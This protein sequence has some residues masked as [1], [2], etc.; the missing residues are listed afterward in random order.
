MPRTERGTGDIGG[1]ARLEALQGVEAVVIPFDHLAEGVELA[2][3][4]PKELN[5]ILLCGI[6]LAHDRVL[7]TFPALGREEV[8]EDGRLLG[9]LNM[10]DLFRAGMLSQRLGL[11]APDPEHDRV[12]ICGNPAMTRELT[13]H[14][15]DTGW[16]LT[17]HRGVGNFSTEVAFVVQ[18]A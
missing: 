14:L 11:P 3:V 2:G 15:K 7:V 9:A 5:W 12:M 6:D 16:T 13:R 8:V 4:V 17:N 1:G 18:H 10:H